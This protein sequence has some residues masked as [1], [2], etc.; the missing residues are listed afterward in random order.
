MTHADFDAAYAQRQ[1]M[2][3]HSGFRASIKR[4]YLN[5]ILAHVVGPTIDFGCG[6][7]QLL[8]RLPPGSMGFEVNRHLV[9]YLNGKGLSAKAYEPETDQLEF[10]DLEPGYFRTFVMAH[11]LEHFDEADQGLRKILR[12]CGRLDIGRVIIVVPSRKGFEFDSTHRT[13]V[14]REYLAD[15]QLLTA[16]GYRASLPT[17]F[18]IPSP[19]LG[20]CFVFNE[21]KVVYHKVGP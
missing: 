2:R 9:D 5:N 18:P 17:Y 10:A 12:A 8:E 16:E 13:F 4:H 19:S 14:N 1:I 7:G 3:A 21:M 15:R 11:V 6:A 20:D